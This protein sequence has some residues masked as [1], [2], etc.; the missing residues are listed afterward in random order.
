LIS[1]WKA[2]LLIEQKST[3]QDLIKAKEQALDYFPHLR[4]YELPRYILISDF[5]TFDLFDL[6]EGNEVKF[7][8]ADLPAHIEAFGFLLGIQ[9]RM[10]KDQDPGNI[11]ASELMGRLHDALKASGYVGHELERFLVRLLFCLFADD[12]GIFE[13]R[14]I[15]LELLQNRTHEDGSETGQWLHSLF[16]VLNTPIE[17]RQRTLDEDLARFPCVKGDLFEE[18]LRTPA[19][20]ATMRQLLIDACSFGWDAISPAIFGSCFSRLWTRSGVGRSGR[21]TRPRKTS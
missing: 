11:Q 15:L 10:F 18:R 13:P 12:T 17:Q 6:D 7:P 19:F 1:F 4:E 8:L 9:K 2:V 14:G 5:Q 21:T 16:E 3:G 20:D